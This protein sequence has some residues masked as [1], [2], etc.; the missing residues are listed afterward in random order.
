VLA[1]DLLAVFDWLADPEALRRRHSVLGIRHPLAL[2]RQAV[3]IRPR[4]A[5]SLR[6]H[7][8]GGFG[9]VT[10]NRLLAS[11]VGELFGLWVQAY[12]RYGSEKKGL[13]TTYFLTIADEPIRQ[14]GELQAVDMVALYDVAAFKQ[15]RPLQGLV[16]GGIL[17]VE[18]TLT[19]PAAIWQA[20]PDA[21]RAEIFARGIHVWALDTASLARSNAPQP[22]LEVRMRG[23]ALAGDFLKVAPFRPRAEMTRDEV[24]AAV[25]GR[26]DR[27]FGKR[28]R[29]VVDA[30][31]RVVTTA[32]DT[33]IDVT[34]TIGARYKPVV[35]L[36]AYLEAVS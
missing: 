1:G 36:P 16:D 15:G 28:G 20:L 4:G 5:Y 9:S 27:F 12:P 21:A 13:P 31:L 23:V 24:L 3:E 7:S 18:T 17:F 32:Y 8:I 34:G 10:T 30:N 25:G 33:V 14:H 29:A 6:G 35:V 2:E 26:L 19:D 22:D 11:L